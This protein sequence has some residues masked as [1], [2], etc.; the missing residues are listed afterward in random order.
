[1]SVINNALTDIANKE[2]G[3]SSTLKRAEIPKVKSSGKLAWAIGGLAL[4]LALGGWAVSTQMDDDYAL[5]LV[6][7]VNSEKASVD[8]AI[9]E[10]VPLSVPAEPMTEQEVDLQSHAVKLSPTVKVSE[11][12]NLPVYSVD[13]NTL[14]KKKTVAKQTAKPSP[15]AK[16]LPASKKVEQKQ[17]I[18]K[19]DV[20]KKPIKI[21]QVEQTKKST[22]LDSGAM[23]VQHVELTSAQI[24]QKAVER[25]KRALDSNDLSR[26]IKEYEKALRYRPS[27]DKSRRKLA[28]L[29][30]GKK[31]VRKSV[32]VLRQGIRL[33]EDNQKL[34]IALSK[35]LV[36]EGQPEAALSPLVHLPE[37]ASIEYLSLRAGLAQQTKTNAIAM[38]TYQQLVLLEGDNAR[39]WLGLAIQQEREL[40]YEAAISSYTNALSRIGL[41]KNSQAFIRDRLSLLK[42]LVGNGNAD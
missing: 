39:W 36:K 30:Y 3:E 2:N 40:N 27:D 9:V 14:V 17:T 18:Q 19:R 10:S 6:D 20:T 12:N 13:R 22:D 28:A 23:Q 31:N 5:D 24:A 25:A 26:A 32:E 33:D 38:E 11:E 41:S 4:S 37:S 35:I 15:A 42:G 1:M 29:Y 16:P 8:S 7:K 34:R 21:A